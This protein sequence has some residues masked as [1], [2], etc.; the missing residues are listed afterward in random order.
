[1]IDIKAREDGGKIRRVAE[2]GN[3]ANDSTPGVYT[4]RGVEG[5]NF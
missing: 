5:I 4:S 3:V 1:L 2:S